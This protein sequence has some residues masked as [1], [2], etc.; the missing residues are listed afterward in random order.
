MASASSPGQG[1]LFAAAADAAAPL[2]VPSHAANAAAALA[3][4][5]LA[6]PLDTLFD[7]VPDDWRAITDAFRAQEAGRALIHRVDTAREAGASIYPADVFAALRLTRRAAVKVVILGQ[8]PYHGPGQAHG[9]SFSVPE[10]VPI[11]PSLRNIRKELQRDLGLRMPTSGQLGAW[12]AQGV[13]LL[14][15]V[16]TVSAGQAASHAGWGWE[17]LTDAL[18]A[19]VAADPGPKV[20]LLWGAHAQRKA[21]LLRAAR[22]A[23]GRS[24]DELLVLQSNHPSPLSASRGPVPFVGNGHFAQAQAFLAQRGLSLDWALTPADLS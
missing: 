3:A 23:A 6:V 24:T 9:L 10:G 22:E 7:A 14:N 1:S 21:P 13:L 15:T 4:P 12:S 17:G 5:A 18:M 19:A 20:A 11:P 8:D 2:A 16:L